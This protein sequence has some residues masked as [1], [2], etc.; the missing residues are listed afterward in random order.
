[1]A[2]IGEQ[3]RRLLQFLLVLA[4]LVGL[5]LIWIH[6]L[7]ALAFL[8]RF[9]FWT[10]VVNGQP[11]FITMNHVVV[12]TVIFLATILATKNIPGLL[13]LSLL[14]SCRWIPALDT[15]SLRFAAI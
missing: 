5:W 2:T 6:V 12:A 11:N 9:Q 1:M 14:A 15:L 4:A 3:S 8:E 7:P 13:E 10:V